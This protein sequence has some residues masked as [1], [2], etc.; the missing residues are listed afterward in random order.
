M[1]LHLPTWKESW[2]DGDPVVRTRSFGHRENP[3]PELFGF[4]AGRW[5][6]M[7]AARHSQSSSPR[8]PR[9]ISAAAPSS[10]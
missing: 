8:H 1:Y 6:D 5:Q 3:S 4:V 2:F 10:G 7:P 9:S